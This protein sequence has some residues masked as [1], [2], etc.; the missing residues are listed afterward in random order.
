MAILLPKLDSIK[1]KLNYLPLGNRALFKLNIF[2][3]VHITIDLKSKAKIN[4][5]RSKLNN[6]TYHCMPFESNPSSIKLAYAILYPSLFFN[7][8]YS[9]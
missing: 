5:F 4:S 1:L 9:S 7:C 3:L 2:P 8:S 6:L